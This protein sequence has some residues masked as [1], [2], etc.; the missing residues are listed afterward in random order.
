VLERANLPIDV[1]RQELLSRNL[2]LRDEVSQANRERELALDESSRALKELDELREANTCQICLNNK[3]DTLLVGCGHL[4]CS[5]C[6][7]QVNLRCPFCRAHFDGVAKFY[8]A[9]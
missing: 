3:I 4:L 7:D 5:A 8:H 2:A 1:E 6:V 9:R